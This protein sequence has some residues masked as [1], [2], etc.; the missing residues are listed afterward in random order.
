MATRQA[1]DLLA[2][3]EAFVVLK[4]DYAASDTLADAIREDVRDTLLPGRAPH[5]VTFLDELPRTPSG[6]IQRFRLRAMARG[7][8]SSGDHR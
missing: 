1:I 6:K 4:P 8:I 7:E 3:P 2:R 5:F